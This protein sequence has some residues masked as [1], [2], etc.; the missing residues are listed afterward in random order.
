MHSTFFPYDR[1]AKVVAGIDFSRA[2]VKILTNLTIFSLTVKTDIGVRLFLRNFQLFLRTLK[3]LDLKVSETSD[4]TIPYYFIFSSMEN[5]TLI[6]RKLDILM[7][8]QRSWEILNIQILEVKQQLHNARCPISGQIIS[9]DE[10][11]NN[12]ARGKYGAVNS[13]L[14]AQC[15]VC[16][17]NM[18]VR[19]GNTSGSK[20]HFSHPP[21]SPYCPTMLLHR[22][23]ILSSAPGAPIRQPLKEHETF[24]GKT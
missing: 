11:E 24:V 5:R 13:P 14:A 6:H 22:S 8:F 9:V 17:A 1:K 12:V 19:A 2:E 21:K 16:S 15:P 20:R 3:L 23:L 10:Y 7:D 18:A 4:Y